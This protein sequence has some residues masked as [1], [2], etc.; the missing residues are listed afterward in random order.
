[1]T[2]ARAAIALLLLAALPVSSRAAL[3]ARYVG[4]LDYEAHYS[5][6]GETRR[7]QSLQRFWTDGARAARLDWYTWAAGDSMGEPESY[8]VA[9]DSVFHRDAPGRRWQLLTGERAE[10][11]RL[12][13]EA[14]FPELLSHDKRVGALSA[15]S[16]RD[17]VMLLDATRA[18]PRLGD[19]HNEVRY[20]YDDKPEPATLRQTL[21]LRDSNWKLEA[22]R[23]GSATSNED[24][25]LAAPS[26]FDPPEQE[27]SSPPVLTPVAD[28]VWSIDMEDIDSRSLVVEFD[29]DLAVIEAAVGSANGERIV[30][31]IRSRWPDKPIGTFFFSHHHPHY[32]GGL[33]AF[34]AEGATVVTT[35]G[36][37]SYVRRLARL[38]FRTAPDRLAKRPRALRLR[39]FRDRFTL[40]DS[41]QRLVAVDIGKASDH[42]AEF[43]AFW[44]PRAGLVFETEQGWVTVADTLR[45]S[46]RAAT[47]L[48]ALSERGIQPE[49][50]VQSWPMRG[51]RAEVSRAELDSLIAARNRK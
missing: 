29:R 18:H 42:T 7:Y 4:T 48:R 36:N 15:T 43:A 25:L 47:F 22:T 12:Q 23:A 38:P 50:L 26:A 14:A 21:Y 5:R 13:A 49:R 11:G 1:M 16:R 3:S 34:V 2:V 6:P 30:D 10:L 33:R 28:G 37:E 35:P 32:L 39:V 45:A 40:A 41:S 19:V 46:R 9:G 17:H 44:L 27:I 20:T 51:N 8:L 24:S 31:T